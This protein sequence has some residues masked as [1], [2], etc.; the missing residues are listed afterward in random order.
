MTRRMK[1]RGFTLIELLV[2]I[3]IIAILVSLLLPAV[4]QAREAARRTQCKSNLKQIGL[5]LHNYHD[6][7]GTFPSGWIGVTNGRADVEGG[8]GFGWG[9]QILSDLEQGPLLDQIDLRQPVW[10]PQHAFL[11][12]AYLPVF[13]CPSD[14]G[15][16]EWELH[17][18][19]G[20]DHDHA[21]E[22]D[23]EGELLMVLPTANYVGSFGPDHLDEYLETP[24]GQTF[25][26]R[27]VFSHNSSVRFKDISDGTSM[28]LLVGERKT[29][30]EREWFSTWA[31][32]VAE[33]EDA[34][35]RV[36]GV[37]DHNPN[38]P[39]SHLD[40]FSSYHPGGVH[41]VF[42]DGSVR[43]VGSSIDHIIFR[44]VATRAG[45]EVVGEF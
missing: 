9:T 35:A 7:F 11:S 43:F 27:G 20:H 1:R 19:H 30:P 14:I 38:S 12:T 15:P 10:A 2:V 4:Q 44:R 3:A 6:S 22:D 17:E 26:S 45:G 29:A 23:E 18:G 24:F 31:G 8:S 37:A 41:F 40:D 32:V 36:L 34:A 21:D 25:Q 28:T 5:A 42:C 16:D 33:G 13:R 39:A